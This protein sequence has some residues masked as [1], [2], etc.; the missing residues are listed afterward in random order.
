LKAA[1]IT[2]GKQLS[3]SLGPK[4]IRVNCVSPGPT[5][6]E[7]GNWSK[8]RDTRVELYEATKAKTA[9]GRLGSAEDIAKTVV[10]LSSPASSYTTG[11]NVVVDGGYTKRVQF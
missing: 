2:Y 10:F 1:L 8:I 7:G 11:V 6:F 5:L 4:G 3:Q 9:L